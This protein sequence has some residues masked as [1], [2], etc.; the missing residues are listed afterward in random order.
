MKVVDKKLNSSSTEL[1]CR[2]NVNVEGL[3]GQARS[4]VTRVATSRPRHSV[5]RGEL[6]S[7]IILPRL[8]LCLAGAFG[9]V[10]PLRNIPSVVCCNLIP[11]HLVLTL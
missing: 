11:F 5:F 8:I 2:H 4:Q 1:I 10:L 9:T 6:T 3:E 7:L